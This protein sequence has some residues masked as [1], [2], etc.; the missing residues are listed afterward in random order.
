MNKVAQQL[1]RHPFNLFRVQYSP[2]YKSLW[3][4][5]LIASPLHPLNETQKRKR[6]ERVKDGIW[7]H[8]TS[9]PD[10]SKSSCVRSWARRRLGTAIVEELKARGFR[11][12]GK[13]VRITTTADGHIAPIE[14]RLDLKGSL[15]LHALPPLVPAKFVEVKAEVGKV[16]D[17]LVQA[18]N[19]A[20]NPQNHPSKVDHRPQWD[21]PS[22]FK[23]KKTRKAA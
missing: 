18:T 2:E 17:I 14:G 1:S 22:L 15:K 13:A 11:E 9:G 23:P 7:W 3:Q 21:P 8:A 6:T 12:N 19:K 16:I 10:L 4:N 20:V 5:R